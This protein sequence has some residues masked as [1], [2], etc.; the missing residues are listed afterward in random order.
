MVRIAASIAARESRVFMNRRRV[1]SSVEA[2]QPGA[3]ACSQ[4]AAGSSRRAQASSTQMASC[5]SKSF[6]GAMRGIVP[7]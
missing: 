4:G 7:E 5:I 6:Q 3:R 1:A 2:S